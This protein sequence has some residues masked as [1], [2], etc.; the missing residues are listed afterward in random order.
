MQKK[1]QSD[2]LEY[3][4]IQVW[5]GYTYFPTTDISVSGIREQGWE[6]FKLLKGAEFDE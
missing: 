2:P 6:S 3:V 4:L 5:S 1:S